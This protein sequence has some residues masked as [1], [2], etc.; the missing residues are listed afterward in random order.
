MTGDL[1]SKTA[2]DL[3][4]LGDIGIHGY[5]W[6][7][8]R[9]LTAALNAMPRL[10]DFTGADT[11]WPAGTTFADRYAAS[12]AAYDQKMAEDRAKTGA[13]G[14]MVGATGT[15]ASLAG[16]AEIGALTKAGDVVKGAT[17]ASGPVLRW[18]GAHSF[19]PALDIGTG[20]AVQGASES[21][22]GIG[23]RA[24]A[25]LV[26]GGENA[27]VA[28]VLS[29]VIS[30]PAQAAYRVLN[31]PMAGA[32]NLI[33]RPANAAYDYLTGGAK[34]ATEAAPEAGAAAAPGAAPD[35]AATYDKF[36]GS[37]TA[38]N[39]N[40]LADFSKNLTERMAASNI[41]AASE[42]MATKIFG[43]TGTATPE[44][45][46]SLRSEASGMRDSADL[47]QKRV[48]EIMVKALD[49]FTGKTNPAKT[50]L[51]PDELNSLMNQYR[52]GTA[53]P[54][55]APTAAPAADVGTPAAAPAAGPGAFRSTLGFIDKRILHPGAVLGAGSTVTSGALAYGADPY[56]ASILGGGTTAALGGLKAALRVASSGA[57]EEIPAA[58][59]VPTRENLARLRALGVIRDASN[60]GTAALFANAPGGGGGG[61]G[62]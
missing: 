18:L 49:D 60:L 1:G 19:K 16:P 23:E 52:Q 58:L 44:E 28:S 34:A 22:G 11:G 9:P 43:T 36:R 54:T 30:V 42:P 47:H 17:E 26:K 48:G 46:A 56:T 8:S 20:S 57:G 40:Q 41:N 15:V 38:Y 55:P 5:T 21:S 29:P 12:E 61:G 33:N 4:S 13:A 50:S 10:G 3:L 39:Y 37:N 51:A 24:K 62:F 31:R 45:I 7:A 25:G 32:F 35:M 2:N 14:K 53:P 59:T 6:G 27:A